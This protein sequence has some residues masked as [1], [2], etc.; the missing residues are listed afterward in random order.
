MTE[1]NKN[2]EKQCDIHVV[3]CRTCST[4][5]H[6][7]KGKCMVSGYSIT[8]ERT[9]PTKCGQNFEKWA[10]KPPKIGLKKRL[11]SFWYGT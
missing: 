8:T 5:G 3:M 7:N 9:Y 2:T 11:L 6:N 1:D 4:C 10:P